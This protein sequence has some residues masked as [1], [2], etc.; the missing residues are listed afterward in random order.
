MPLPS[1]PS[2]RGRRLGAVLAAF[3]MLGLA[4]CTGHPSE[5]AARGAATGMAGALVM[6][7]PAIVAVAAGVATGAT[8][9][10]FW[11]A[12]QTRRTQCDQ[13]ARCVY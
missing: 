8:A 3:A 7:S 5:G 11:Q 6:G 1:L 9:N 12:W 13:L 4:A 10:S 2:R